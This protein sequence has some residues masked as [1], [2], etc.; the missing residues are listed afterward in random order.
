[1]RVVT[2]SLEHLKPAP[3]VEPR[4]DASRGLHAYANGLLLIAAGQT[5]SL[6]LTALLTN[7]G[8]V[9]PRGL[10]ALVAVLGG[11][12][13]LAVAVAGLVLVLAG[14]VRC[15]GALNGSRLRPLA[16][17]A[18][19]RSSIGGL[20]VVPGLVATI[21]WARSVVGNWIL[22]GA[23]SSGSSGVFPS[24]SCAGWP[25]SFVTKSLGR[26]LTVYIVV[27]LAGCVAGRCSS[28]RR[29]ARGQGAPCQRRSGCFRRSLRSSCSSGSRPW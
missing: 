25:G 23:C 17:T 5:A 14:L 3:P 15:A 10:L 26:R 6:L 28:G 9:L 27:W 4:P 20:P 13:V 1:M 29:S 16:F 24:C 8:R 2:S 7:G 12:A 21:A 19:Y 22:A 11:L 18:A